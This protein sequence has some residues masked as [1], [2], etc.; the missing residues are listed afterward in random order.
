MG[1]S[2]DRHATLQGE[3]GGALIIL[4]TYLD[5]LAGAHRVSVLSLL[6]QFGVFTLVTLFV[7]LLYPGRWSGGRAKGTRCWL[8]RM[9]P[10]AVQR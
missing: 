10:L 3:R 6:L 1:I 2:A 7:L 5:L 8:G 4:N 9:C